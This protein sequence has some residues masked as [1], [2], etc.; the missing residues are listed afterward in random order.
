MVSDGATLKKSS[1]RERR[2]KSKTSIRSLKLSSEEI[3]I[4]ESFIRVVSHPL[5]WLY[6]M[7]W[8]KDEHDPYLS[9]KKFPTHKEYIQELCRLWY[10]ENLLLVA[11]SRQMLITWLFSACFLWDTQFKQ[12]RLVFF[13]SKKEEDADRIVQRAW[14]IYENQPEWIRKLFPA[15]YSYC[16]IKFT[17][18]KSEIWGIPQGG[19]QIRSHTAS[20]I[21][22][23]EMAFQDEAEKAYTAAK[24]T[25]IGGGKFVGVSTANPGFFQYLINNR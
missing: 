4:K 9:K 20:G 14:F 11:K 12:N 6:E 25:L 22:S 10:D 5:Y 17:N 1:T 19:D 18:G 8:T 13:Q 7:V 23:D 2:L 3:A 21:F 24:P 16:H 15:V